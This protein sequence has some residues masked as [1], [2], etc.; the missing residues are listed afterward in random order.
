MEQIALVNFAVANFS[1]FMCWYKGR[2]FFGLCI[3]NL[4]TKVGRHH[5]IVVVS[6]FSGIHQMGKSEVSVQESLLEK[7]G[8]RFVS[9]DDDG[10]E[11]KSGREE[12][13]EEKTKEGSKNVKKNERGKKIKGVSGDTCVVADKAGCHQRGRLSWKKMNVGEEDDCG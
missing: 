9:K 12:K 6:S 2:V 10:M 3:G 7:R 5:F 11:G 1:C 4:D 13:R 8:F